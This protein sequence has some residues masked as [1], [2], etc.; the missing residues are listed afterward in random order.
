MQTAEEKYYTIS[1]GKE[2]G[3]VFTFEVGLG[4]CVKYCEAFL[5]AAAADGRNNS[6]KNLVR[7]AG[8]IL[9]GL[10]HENVTKEKFLAPPA[11]T[12]G[13]MFN[14]LGNCAHPIHV[15]VKSDGLKIFADN[16][17]KTMGVKRLDLTG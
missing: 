11:L 4:Q 1:V 8:E 9:Y 6:A 13:F 10:L 5:K 2:G 12:M 3:E 16:G 17:S 14:L 7:Y 15:I